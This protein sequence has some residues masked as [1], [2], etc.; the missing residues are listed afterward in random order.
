MP[1]P[2]TA[3]PAEWRRFLA[4]SANNRAWEIA[5]SGDRTRHGELLDA[6]HASAWLWSAIGTEQHRMRATMLLALAHAL[7]GH[8]EIALAH[9]RPAREYFLAHEAPDWELAFTHAIFALAAREAGLEGEY[10]A[11]YALAEA[12]LAAIA[13]PQDREV[14]LRT[15]VQVPRP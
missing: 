6:A 9:A 11:A 5:E 3:D 4:M 12:A 13:D 7:A 1:Q 15:F 10:R 8:G 2:T 14:V